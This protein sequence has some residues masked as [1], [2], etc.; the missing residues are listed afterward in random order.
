MPMGKKVGVHFN[1]G[2][3]LNRV[4][5]DLRAAIRMAEAAPVGMASIASAQGG[6]GVIK[7]LRDALVLAESALQKSRTIAQLDES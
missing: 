6:Q 7:S 5:Q 3:A 2:G 1:Y 4:V